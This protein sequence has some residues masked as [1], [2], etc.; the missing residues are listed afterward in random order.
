MHVLSYRSKG[1]VLLR[2]RRLSADD[3]DDYKQWRAV[4][5]GCTRGCIRTHRSAPASELAT[6]VIPTVWH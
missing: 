6:L 2:S 1:R 4:R 5:V 3:D